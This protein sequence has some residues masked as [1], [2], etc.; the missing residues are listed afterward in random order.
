[1]SADTRTAPSAR[2]SLVGGIVRAT[3]L[4]ALVTVCARIAGFVRY[5]VFGA[6]VGAGDIGTAYASANLV[7]SV[8]F[9]VAA[10]GALAAM[11]IPLVAGLPAARALERR[12]TEVSAESIVAVLSLWTLAITGVLALLLALAADPIAALI[13]PGDAPGSASLTALGARML[14]VFALQLPCYGITIVCGAYLQSRKRF[15]WPAVAPLIS[16]LVVMASYVLYRATASSPLTVATLP[17]HSEAILAWGTT[18]GVVAMAVSVI[19]PA[20]RQGLRWRWQWRLPTGLARSALALAGAGLAAV[21]AQQ[22]VMALIL[23]LAARAGGTGTLPLFQYAQAVYLLP[24]AILLVPVMTS[25]FPHL[26]ELRLVGESAKFS[27]MARGSMQSVVVL[28]AVGGAGLWGA[29][30]GVDRFFMAID[31]TGVRGVG[32]ATAALALGLI[33]FGIITHATRILNAQRRAGEALIV[34]STPWL[35]GAFFIVIT[36]LTSAPRRTP[37]AATLFALCIALGMLLGAVVAL[38]LV[39]ERALTAADAATLRRSILAAVAA[40]SVASVLGLLASRLVAGWMHGPWASMVLGGVL[41]LA[42]AALCL[43]LIA[44]LDREH[45]RTLI[46]RLRMRALRRKVRSS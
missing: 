23:V 44:V 7:P 6:N 16:S 41:A 43:A 11:V 38:A 36:V 37:E 45:T 22:G 35:L 5:L 24:F 26:S 28:A 34:G 13:F 4:I 1:M 14:R 32:A 19:V 3:G 17:A 31:R 9:E 18:L 42:S 40:S 30:L 21:A 20:A 46:Y 12:A 25:V 27:A 15:F 39:Q 10:G 8:M 29:A 33:A 2:P